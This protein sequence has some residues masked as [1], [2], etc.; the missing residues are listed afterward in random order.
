MLRLLLLLLGMQEPK[1]KYARVVT[2][3]KAPH[4]CAC[5]LI[6]T[7]QRACSCSTCYIFPLASTQSVSFVE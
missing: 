4:D 6:C 1:V 7:Q 3:A 2:V 5:R